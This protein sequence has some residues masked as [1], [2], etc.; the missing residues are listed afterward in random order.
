MTV[1]DSV[2][3]GGVVAT[4]SHGAKTDARTIAE[5]VVG[6]EI[7]DANGELRKF[8]DEINREEMA[9]AR[10]NLGKRIYGALTLGKVLRISTR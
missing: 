8:S 4:G 7:V 5:Q 2:R 6:F 10:V 3:I 1:L 9:V